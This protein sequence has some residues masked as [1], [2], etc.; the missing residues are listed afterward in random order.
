M[1]IR[2]R[3][4]TIDHYPD[5][6]IIQITVEG[7]LLGQFIQSLGQT[8]ILFDFTHPE[9]TMVQLPEGIKKLIISVCDAILQLKNEE[10]HCLAAHLATRC[11]EAL[12]Y[13]PNSFMRKGQYAIASSYWLEVLTCVRDWE[14]RH[15]AKIHKGH[16]HFFLAYAC[17]LSGDLETGFVYAY[18]AI[19]D[20]EA[21]GKVLSLIHI[22]EPTRPY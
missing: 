11:F 13:F 4:M 20:D 14:S 22:S 5:G 9:R 15:N 21:L 17:L 1:C 6:E 2:D 16:P 12:T 7:Q 8:R 10:K 18:N 3:N 19:K